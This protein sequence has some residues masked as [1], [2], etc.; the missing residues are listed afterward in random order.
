MA[1]LATQK[2]SQLTIHFY[3]YILFYSISLHSILSS[4]ILTQ[5]GPGRN[6]GP[7]DPEAEPADHHYHGGGDVHLDDEVER[8]ASEHEARLQRGPVAGGQGA[9]EA[10]VREVHHL[11]VG[12]RDV[13]AD[14]DRLGVVLHHP[15]VLDVVRRVAPTATE[16]RRERL[17]SAP[18]LR[19]EKRKVFW[20]QNV[21]M[22]N[23]HLNFDKLLST[24]FCLFR[25]I[26]RVVLDKFSALEFRRIVFDKFCALEFRRIVF[27]YF[28]AL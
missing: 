7:G 25:C 28:S 12:Q 8:V 5:S 22:K 14:L 4:L 1:V 3:C 24:I 2:L 9:V 10:A 6:G 21:L 23:S 13:V 15:E 11:E 19:L 17:K 18:H 27:D 20:P 26:R 16:T